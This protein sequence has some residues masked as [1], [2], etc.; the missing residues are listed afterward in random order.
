MS[1]TAR[2]DTDTIDHLFLELSQFT[3][4]TTGK[5]IKLTDALKRAN[6][7]LRSVSNVIKRE[8][9]ETNWP[10]LEAA[11]DKALDEQHK[12]LFPQ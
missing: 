8:G 6:D 1:N 10:A 2:F 9:K 11:V 3:K 7:V 4:A 12:I 5:E